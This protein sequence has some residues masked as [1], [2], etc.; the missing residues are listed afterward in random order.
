[1]QLELGGMSDGQV[2]II[3]PAPKVIGRSAPA[4]TFYTL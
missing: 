3:I 1:M 2:E 4:D